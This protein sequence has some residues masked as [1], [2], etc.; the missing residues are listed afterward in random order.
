[1]MLIARKISVML[2]LCLIAII[3]CAGKKNTAVVRDAEKRYQ[4]E[5]P[6]REIP[7]VEWDTLTSARALIPLSKEHAYRVDQRVGVEGDY[8]IFTV[9]T[10]HGTYTVK[11][12]FA[13]AEFCR[14]ARIIEM[15]LSSPPSST[16][17]KNLDDYFTPEKSSR[18]NIIISRVDSIAQLGRTFHKNFN[19]W[20]NNNAAPT[21]DK[22][23][24]QNTPT[25]PATRR[26]AYRLRTDAY[27]QNEAL[28]AVLQALS[29]NENSAEQWL[30]RGQ[31]FIPC[32]SDNYLTPLDIAPSWGATWAMAGGK[33]AQAEKFIR[34]DD[35]SEIFKKLV[36]FYRDNLH[37]DYN[38]NIALRNL[39][40]NISYSPRQQVY[41]AWY[42]AAINARNTPDAINY[43]SGASTAFRAEYNLSQLAM[44]HAIG[45][46][47]APIARFVALQ[48]Q[49]AILTKARQIIVVPLWDHTR[50]RSNV[51]HLLLEVKNFGKNY[52]VSNLQIWLAGDGDKNVVNTATENGITV[53]LNCA[54]DDVFR[55]TPL[56][57][58]TYRALPS[59]P[60]L[61][62]A[63]TMAREPLIYQ[64]RAFRPQPVHQIQ[65]K[66][67]SDSEITII[68][69]K[70]SWSGRLAIEKKITPPAPMP[71]PVTSIISENE[72]GSASGKLPP[73]GNDPVKI[74]T[75]EF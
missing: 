36:M 17:P 9:F 8:Y 26:L 71:I 67:S 30:P 48:N 32:A 34:D 35:Y 62:N 2:G 37:V 28:R 60:I 31:F 66:L 29:T 22:I 69:D 33:S 49:L 74:P 46:G 3:T 64:E 65:P 58:L 56:R 38:D 12:L 15:L 52:Q 24:R 43:L 11:G 61:E 23:N 51:R 19:E 63:A 10:P 47:H 14:Q 45:V 72:T 6:G 21:L 16:L 27:T 50:Q 53:R 54:T 25:T 40:S 4:A 42:L 1:M 44:L 55:F 70:P 41:L 13:L 39:L 75:N 18:G 68:P 57:E 20:E 5:F 59:D 7:L 73:V